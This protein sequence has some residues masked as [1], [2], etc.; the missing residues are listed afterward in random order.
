MFNNLHNSNPVRCWLNSK[1]R[2]PSIR[3]EPEW[4]LVIHFS[5][6]AEFSSPNN[7]KKS[8]LLSINIYNCKVLQLIKIEWDG[9]PISKMGNLILILNGL[10]NYIEIWKEKNN[11]ITEINH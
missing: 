5:E 4:F 8:L 11:L 7:N 2:L 9:L 3:E 10:E 1:G 6:L